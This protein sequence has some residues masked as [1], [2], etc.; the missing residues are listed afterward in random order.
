MILNKIKINYLK[1]KKINKSIKTVKTNENNSLGYITSILASASIPY[2]NIKANYFKKNNGNT[3]LKIISD[4]E[5]GLPYGI[6]PRIIMIWICTEIKL[7]KS[8]LIYLGRTQNEFI[9]KL[10]IKPTGG[11]NGSI[12]RIKKQIMKLFHST[13]TLINEKENIH[14][15][16]NFTIVDNGFLFWNKNSSN[17]I[18]WNNKI[19]LSNKFFKETLATLLPIDLRIIKILR[20]PLA[21]DIYIWITWKIIKVKNK[22]KI[23]ISWKN[24]KLQF[25]SNYCK[26]SKGLYNFKK[27]FINKIIN[28]FYIYK[29]FNFFYLKKYLCLIF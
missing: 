12:T 20:S 17:K 13:I 14:N 1:K 25:G 29:K 5:Y 10:G 18:Y 27:E 15:F 16:I 11:I 9:K 8:N 28:V 3:S 24:L 2:S 7:N 26:S 21:I 6:I 4:P 23:L 22:K 19:I